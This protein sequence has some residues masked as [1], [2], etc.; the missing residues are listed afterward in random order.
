MQLGRR[1]MPNIALSSGCIHTH[2]SRGALQVV[3]SHALQMTWLAWQ[4]I[5]LLTESRCVL[6]RNAGARKWHGLWLTLLGSLMT[7]TE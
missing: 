4:V 2:M 5:C 3:T 7:S 1:F 6:Q